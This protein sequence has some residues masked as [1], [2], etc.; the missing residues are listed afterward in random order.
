ML[1]WCT[2]GDKEYVR[3]AG[4]WGAEGKSHLLREQDAGYVLLD[5]AHSPEGDLLVLGALILQR[6]QFSV[7]GHLGRE[8]LVVLGVP[9]LA[10]EEAAD[11]VVREPTS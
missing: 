8:Y 10:R 3:L 1:I 9:D 6:L 4:V 7:L 2:C 11:D 5:V